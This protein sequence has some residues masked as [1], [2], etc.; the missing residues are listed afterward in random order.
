MN[1]FLVIG[2]PTIAAP[3]RSVT[4]PVVSNGSALRMVP[5]MTRTTLEMT[6]TTTI[7]TMNF[8]TPWKS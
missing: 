7:T 5:E 3:L 6:T 2:S 8:S 4:T 1:P